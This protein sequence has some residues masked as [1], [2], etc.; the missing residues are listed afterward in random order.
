[1]F[2]IDVFIITFDGLKTVGRCNGLYCLSVTEGERNSVGNP[3]TKR[4]VLS[5]DIRVVLL[6]PLF[7][8]SPV[9]VPAICLMEDLESNWVGKTKKYNDQAGYKEREWPQKAIVL[10][11]V[12][13]PIKIEQ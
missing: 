10:R 4:S 6:V 9:S 5:L 7:L 2:G 1:M 3:E 11:I 8:V 13:V 12:N